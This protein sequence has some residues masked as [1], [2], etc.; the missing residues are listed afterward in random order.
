MPKRN[1]D[2]LGAELDSMVNDSIIQTNRTDKSIRI[3]AMIVD[4]NIIK[5]HWEKQDY[6]PMCQSH[7]NRYFKS[8]LRLRF[9]C[10][11]AGEG[12]P[13]KNTQ[14]Y[15]GGDIDLSVESQN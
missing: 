1:E 7:F 6:I 10:M 15:R 8:P 9:V 5:R 12:N 11:L 14:V 2:L 3:E 13:S 4:N